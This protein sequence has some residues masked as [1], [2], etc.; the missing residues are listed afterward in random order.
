[1]WKKACKYAT[2][3]T[4]AYLTQYISL[5]G[6]TDCSMTEMQRLDQPYIFGYFA[7]SYQVGQFI[8]KSLAKYL[9]LNKILVYPSINI[10]LFT[11]LFFNTY[12]RFL[13]IYCIM[14][15]IFGIGFFGG[16]S[17]MSIFDTILLEPG[18][19]MKEREI[20]T[21]YTALSISWSIQAS[22]LFILL[23]QNTFYKDQC[24]KH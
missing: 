13:P 23:M 8:S 20:M 19:T 24:I 9:S 5:Q 6:L 1:M 11:T 18:T 17:Y 3:N 15:M 12:F 2:C 7:I 4:L 10:V 16:L 14:P 21:N 22:A